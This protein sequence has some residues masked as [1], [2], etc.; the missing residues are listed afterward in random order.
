MRDA[1]QREINYLRISV[2]DRCNLRCYYCM[3]EE[4]VKLVSHREILRNEEIIKIVEA[5][6][7]VGIKK[8]RLTGGEPLVRKGLCGLIESIAAIKGIDDV[9]LTTNAILLSSMG[10]EL[11]K[12][13]L[14]RVNISL[15]T[16]NPD[17]YRSITRHGDIRQ[18][19]QGIETAL[20]TGF[21]P[22]KINCVV[23]KGVNCHEVTELAALTIRYPLHIRFI[24]LMPIGNDS[25]RLF[26]KHVPV[27]EIRS[28]IELAFGGL[29]KAKSPLGNG[30]ANYYTIPGAKGT[31]GFISPI[32]HSFC[33]SCNRL[34]LTSDG[35]I[36]QC[37]YSKK[38]FDIKTPLR[39]GAG[40]DELAGI[41]AKALK[42]KP[43]HHKFNRG[44]HDNNRLMPQIGG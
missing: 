30:P 6:G 11:K 37:L 32:S 20:D 7:L 35:M 34:R 17:T 44:W 19:W 25:I 2:T 8:I 43:G 23:I 14:K 18:V 1:Y 10:M 40:I 31:I 5:A 24:E 38:E 36:R 41:F 42:D 28:S 22:V 39:N 29:Q 15:D 26:K 12:A 33:Y 27:S 4:G 21:N 3:P 16:L 9:A 13:G